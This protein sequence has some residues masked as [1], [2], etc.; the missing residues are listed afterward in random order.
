[1]KF[2]NNTPY[3]AGRYV[4][5]DEKGKDL[6]IIVVKAT[7]EFNHD[8]S[9]TISDKQ[10]KV[11]LADQYFGDSETTG[12]KYASDVT[13]G[14][15]SS[16]IA[17]IGHAV[18]MKEKTKKSY[19][20]FNVG[21]IRKKIAVFGDRYWQ[22]ILGVTKISSPERFTK[23][24]L[25]YENCFGGRDLSTKKEKHHEFETGNYIGT[26][27]KA[28]KSKLKI[29]EIKL[30]NLED[31]DNLIKSLKD[32]PKP[33]GL[34]FIN[35]NWEPRLGFAGT[36]DE[37]WQ[38][39]KMPLL[40]DDFNT[41]VNH[42]AHPDLIYPGFLKGGE[43]V[44]IAGVSKKGPFKFNIPVIKPECRVEITGE[45]SISHKMN[46]EKLVI[47]SDEK[48]AVLVW[49]CSI[50]V[51]N[52]LYEVQNIECRMKDEANVEDE[53]EVENEAKVENES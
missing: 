5:Q 17:L 39:N 38:K 49:N 33:T 34:G 24:P 1:M 4:V 3:E 36:Y 50:D 25:V 15:K 41:K 44:L 20:I 21:K 11:E 31:P 22:S 14:K 8:G 23:I 13:Y 10:E 47:N 30:P 40:P 18:A 52:K 46:I 32:R 7:Y 53:A 6:L 27:L 48:N 37:N 16:D 45:G 51:H 43:E 26:G 42:A 28:K 12:I 35:P 9:L 2:D 29:K 19:V